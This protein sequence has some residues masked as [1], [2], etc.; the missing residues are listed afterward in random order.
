MSK[1]KEELDTQESQDEETQSDEDTGKSDEGESDEPDYK[2]LYE[3][4][5]PKYEKA[6]HDKNGLLKKV[7]LKSQ[8]K[9]VS[10]SISEERLDKLELRMLDPDLTNEQVQEILLIKKAK[11]LSDAKSAYENPL[12]QSWL[13]TAKSD[14][15]KKAKI[16]RAIP[17]AQGKT[18]VDNSTKK[19]LQHNDNWLKSMPHEST[20]EVAK[21]LEEHFFGNK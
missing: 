9:E 10:S 12:I 15:E 21:I 16:N 11:G 20:D 5:K 13:T 4:L 3:E 1:E 14:S 17:R 19:T 2:A 6:K 18:S 7:S 8:P